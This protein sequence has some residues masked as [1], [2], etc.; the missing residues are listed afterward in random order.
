MSQ[1]SCRLGNGTMVERKTY[2]TRASQSWAR[3]S[4]R[5]WAAG[6]IATGQKKKDP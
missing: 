4:N 2:S 1:S 5:P 6:R 3:S